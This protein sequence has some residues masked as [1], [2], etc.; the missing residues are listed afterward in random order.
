MKI[1]TLIENTLF[2]GFLLA[3]HGLSVYI[4]DKVK[5]LIDTGQGKNFIDNAK[6]LDISIEDI[7][8]LV[9]SHG[10]YDHAGGVSHF[11]KLNKKARIFAGKD[12]FVPKYKN[13]ADFIGIK[14]N[15][16]AKQDLKRFNF[17]EGNTEITPYLHLIPSAK[18]V[19]DWDT[20]FENMYIKKDDKK[21]LMKLMNFATKYH[22]SY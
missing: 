20:H 7:D 4:E 17:I 9:L 21:I 5:I 10:H 18:I 8:F 12:F 16:L 13:K 15:I 19:N 2:N 14:D 6:K 22:L 3:E 11:L 1:I